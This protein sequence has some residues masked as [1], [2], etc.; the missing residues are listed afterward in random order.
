MGFLLLGGLKLKFQKE[1]GGCPVLVAP[2]FGPTGR[3]CC[4]ITEFLIMM[5]DFVRSMP[6][7]PG[8][9]AITHGVGRT[10]ELRSLEL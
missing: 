5:F 3:G 9:T 7:A 6:A 8:S 1:F 10:P 4:L 2:V